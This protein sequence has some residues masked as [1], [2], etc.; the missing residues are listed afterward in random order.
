MSEWRKRFAKRSLHCRAA[1]KDGEREILIY[2][3]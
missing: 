1:R 3:L 2:I